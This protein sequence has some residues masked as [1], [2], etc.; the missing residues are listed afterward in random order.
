MDNILLSP[1]IYIL[2]F[3]FKIAQTLSP[4]SIGISIIILSILVFIVTLPL[5]KII[6]MLISKEE[7]KKSKIK[8]LIEEINQVYNGQVRFF[9]TKALYKIHGINPYSD[10]FS[11]GK[12]LI[13]IPFFIAAYHYL[14]SLDI[15]N[16]NSFLLIN[17]LSKPDQL[18]PFGGIYLNAL[19]VLMFII[20]ALSAFIF[21]KENKNEFYTL[22]ITGILFLFLLYPMPSSLVLYWT[23]NNIISM[24]V[25]VIRS[26]TWILNVYKKWNIKKSLYYFINRTDHTIA[27]LCLLTHTIISSLCLSSNYLLITPYYSIILL[28]ALLFIIYFYNEVTGKIKSYEDNDFLNK[29]Q[30]LFLLLG[31]FTPLFIYAKKNYI[32]IQDGLIISFFCYLIIPALI[33]YSALSLL[34][35]FL[36]KKERILTYIISLLVFFNAPILNNI[37][38]V[39]AEHAL[40][41][42]L[43]VFILLYLLSLKLNPKKLKVISYM[44]LFA[45]LLSSIDFLSVHLKRNSKSKELLS[46]IKENKRTNNLYN[47]I[48]SKLKSDQMPNVYFLI[49][50]GLTGEKV[51]DHYN[52][53]YKLDYLKDY[54]FQIYGD[55]LSNHPTSLKSISSVLEISNKSPIKKP[56]DQRKHMAGYNLVDRLFESINRQRTY[57]AS[58]HFFKGQIPKKGSEIVKIGD[59]NIN[60][61]LKGVLIG[62]FKFDI[63]IKHQ[64]DKEY[65]QKKHTLLRRNK[66]LIYVHNPYPGHS[67]NSGRCLEEDIPTYGK[68]LQEAYTAMKADLKVIL[69]NDPDSIII[70]AGDHGGHLSGDCKG[71]KSKNYIG[72]TLPILTE[73]NGTF[74]AIRWPDLKYKKYDKFESLQGIFLS[75][76]AYATNDKSLLESLPKERI[77]MGDIC[78]DQK[79]TVLKGK[80]KGK[81]V[82]DLLKKFELIQF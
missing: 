19:P 60:G 78:T 16:N 7:V 70:V 2:Q 32:Y 29:T 72:A 12:L 44:F 24:I 27:F 14:S 80:D 76:F 11:M 20:N 53:K 42:S 48:S 51:M 31:S 28:S 47:R 61:L 36:G 26:R 77:C 10:L 74:V 22:F 62:E 34:L 9:Y 50:D 56:S 55:I 46:K 13:Q 15:F 68:R 81:N 23:F 30:S 65:E 64:F 52:L 8:H 57:L 67:Q 43:I 37:L 66:G 41:Y 40:P 39:R 49:Y 4:T 3:L 1:F 6:E 58:N 63:E 79:G 21:S 5:V 59:H 45:F 75:I 82:F 73:T 17:D 33:M 35:T 25:E 71:M 38:V 54:N 18:I 69:A